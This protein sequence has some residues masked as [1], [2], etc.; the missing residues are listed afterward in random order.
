[1]PSTPR[2]PCARMREAGYVLAGPGSPTLRAAAVD[3]R[4][5]P[6]RRSPTSSRDGGVRDD[7]ER[8][9]PDA[10]RRAPSPSTRSTRSAR[11]RTGSTA[12]TCW[13]RRRACEPPSSR[14]TTTPRAATTTR[15][16]ATWA[17]DGCGSS[18]RACRPTRSSSGVDSHT[19]LVLDLESADGNGLGA[20]RRDDPRLGTER[21]LSERNRRADRDP[22]T[23]RSPAGGGRA[24][25]YR[26]RTR[27]RHS[28]TSRDRQDRERGAGRPADAGR[29]G[30]AR[31]HVRGRT[32]T[33]GH[34]GCGR[35]PALTSISRSRP[36]FGAAR[37]APISTTR[38]RHS[39]H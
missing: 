11:T 22:R 25:R 27:E 2:R 10:R 13:G 19:A 16:S 8:R 33:R 21:C 36:V 38:R 12:S 39:G 37:T 23:G 6:R 18:R 5:D 32:R 30:A 26:R 34:S 29:D 31:G 9:G 1:M 28:R 14:T 3:R 35:G 15:G 4:S 24:R 20:G 17:S 7:G